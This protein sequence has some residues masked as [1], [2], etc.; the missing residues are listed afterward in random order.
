MI[1]QTDVM[2]GGEEMEIQ[3]LP[4]T[5]A[6]VLLGKLAKIAGGAGVGVSDIPSRIADL[7]EVLH[8]GNML[9]G[10]LDK[11]DPS[12][13]Q[14]LIKSILVSSLVK[15]NMIDEPDEDFTKW[16]DARFSRKIDELFV[17]L[18]A[19]FVHNYGS[20]VDW[21]KKILGKIP[22]LMEESGLATPPDQSSEETQT[23][24]DTPNS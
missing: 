15:P 4:A 13:A 3:S 11:I 16:Y 14:I 5:K 8:V 20:P 2:V 18:T 24:P 10:I 19:I 7:E 22:G 1:E 17:L 23:E 21:V 9:M 12:E 6:L